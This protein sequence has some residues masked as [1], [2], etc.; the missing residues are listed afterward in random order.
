MTKIT[1]YG[2]AAVGIEADNGVKILIDPMLKDNPLSPVKPD[3]VKDQYDI[4]VVTH[5]HFDH[6]GDAPYI[7]SSSS[8]PVLFA[9]YDLEAYLNREFKI[10]WERMVPTNIGGYVD[11]KGV[12]LALT[13]AVH[14]GV[15]SD[16][17]GVVVNDGK[18]VIYHAGD[19]GLF[20]DMEII[21]KVFKP[22]V[23]LLP[24]GGRFT[25]D[26]YQAAMAV[27]MLRPR[28][29]AIPIHYNTWDL[30]KVNP[31]VFIEEVKRR[32]YEALVMRPGQTVEL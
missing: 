21:G 31:D 5:D 23:V 4:I 13:M 3:E 24:I 2:H 19:T 10:P 7:M 1:W 17:T 27:E 6:L 22:D 32:G 15:Y 25:M 14:T 8:K 9:S 28:K 26:P 29:L 20:A 16:P 18:N 11:V 12:K 30:I